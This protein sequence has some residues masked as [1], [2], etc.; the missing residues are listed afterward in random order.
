[1]SKGRGSVVAMFDDIKWAVRVNK[2]AQNGVGPAALRLGNREQAQL[3]TSLASVGR[4]SDALQAFDSLEEPSPRD[5]AARIALADSVPEAL[6]LFEHVVRVRQRFDDPS[7]SGEPWL[8]TAVLQRCR[9][10][11]HAAGVAQALALADAAGLRTNDFHY[12]LALGVLASEALQTDDAAAFTAL[13]A[14]MTAA[15]ASSVHS[16]QVLLSLALA[17]RVSAV[18]AKG[19]AA[20]VFWGDLQRAETYLLLDRGKDGC[21]LMALPTHLQERYILVYRQA[22]RL[23]SKVNEPLRA[24]HLAERLALA[25]AVASESARKRRRPAA[26]P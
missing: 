6:Q 16:L 17:G 13:Y 23:C 10:A 4:R 14:R 19:L 5:Y 21:L 12:T 3:I 20:A 8:L 11:S 9:A 25:K 15:G 7:L 18:T 1:M 24:K 2:V 22:L 26:P